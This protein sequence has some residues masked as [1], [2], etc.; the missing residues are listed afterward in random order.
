VKKFKTQNLIIINLFIIG[1]VFF[2]IILFLPLLS[3][4]RDTAEDP[5]WQSSQNEVRK[6]NLQEVMRFSDVPEKEIYFKRP[7]NIKLDDNGNIYIQDNPHILKFGPDG[8]FLIKLIGEGQGP[9]EL[10]DDFIGNLSNFALVGNEVIAFSGY[11]YKIMWFNEKGE[12]QKEKKLPMGR[13]PQ[14]FVTPNLNY[15]ILEEEIPPRNKLPNV[16]PFKYSILLCLII[17]DFKDKE[18]IHTW[19]LEGM[20]DKNDPA[21]T[22]RPE[23]VVVDSDTLVVN[24]TDEYEFITLNLKNDKKLKT[25]THKYKREKFSTK[26]KK[27]YYP[28]IRTMY[29]VSPELWV[30]T[31]TKD[32]DGF[33]LIC[34]HD[35]ETGNVEEFYLRFPESDSDRRY[36]SRSMTI[37]KGFIFM[38]EQSP[39]GFYNIVKYQIE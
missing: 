29:Y 31:W 36:Y 6:V 19:S 15:Y 27:G 23:Y 12:F 28:A 16:G 25:F 32:K 11:P 10:V 34:A 33:P 30:V 4:T 26:S 20:A 1:H 39:E 5:N 8:K 9:G 2:L 24:T 3:Y 14:Y 7:S 37:V 38:I 18:V 21:R 35:L 22:K 13:G 17:P